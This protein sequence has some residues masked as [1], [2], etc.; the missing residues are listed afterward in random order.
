MLGECHSSF[1]LSIQL[2][3][4]MISWQGEE[5]QQTT[6]GHMVCTLP[7]HYPLCMNTR[8]L[9]DDC[10]PLKIGFISL[11]HSITSPIWWHPLGRTLNTAHA[12]YS[13]QARTGR[14]N[15]HPEIGKP[16]IPHQL[17][18]HFVVLPYA[19]IPLSDGIE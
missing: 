10:Y 9:R 11:Q 1:P 16:L 14:H 8:G 18:V 19:R 2:L 5:I 7:P 15:C 3:T 17:V 6:W 13:W 4:N 12:H